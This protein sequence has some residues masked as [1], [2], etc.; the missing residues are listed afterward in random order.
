MKPGRWIAATVVFV[1]AGGDIY[2]AGAASWKTVALVL[3]AAVILVGAH[4]FDGVE[5]GPV[6]VD[7]DDEEGAS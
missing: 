5:A 1:F 7:A 4:A 6:S 3:V 2:V